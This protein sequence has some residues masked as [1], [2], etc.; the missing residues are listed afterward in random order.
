LGSAL[1]VCV[2][3]S[4]ITQ[5]S[6]CK[7]VFVIALAK[8]AVWVLAEGLAFTCYLLI[9]LWRVVWFNKLTNTPFMACGY[10]KVATFT[11]TVDAEH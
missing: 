9:H 1:A 3:C 6:V 11:T 2:C 5:L 8:K 7:D 4:F 10:A